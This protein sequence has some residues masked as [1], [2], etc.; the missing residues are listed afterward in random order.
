MLP[1]RSSEPNNIY[2]P[3]DKRFLPVV[4]FSCPAILSSTSQQTRQRL[5]TESPLVIYKLFQQQNQHKLDGS[6][7]AVYN[8]YYTYINLQLTSIM[9]AFKRVY[10]IKIAEQ[11]TQ[12]VAVCNKWAMLSHKKV[13]S[14]KW[15]AATG[16]AKRVAL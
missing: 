10:L 15:S 7:I 11:A 14:R 8:V 6:S 2:L 1:T 3:S 12:Y 13:E 5:C 4:L 9:S 16:I